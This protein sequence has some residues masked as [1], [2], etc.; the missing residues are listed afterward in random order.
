LY[1]IRLGSLAVI[2]G[3]LRYVRCAHK[4]GLSTAVAERPLSANKRR[5]VSISN[6]K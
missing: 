4:S 5:R 1:R 2:P 6:A 3:C